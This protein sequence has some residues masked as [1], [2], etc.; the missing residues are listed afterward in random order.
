M[1]NVLAILACITIFA[2]GFAVGMS[3]CNNI[4]LSTIQDKDNL[5]TDLTVKG[6]NKELGQ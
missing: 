4:W 2:S 1:K 5:I 6:L 3:V